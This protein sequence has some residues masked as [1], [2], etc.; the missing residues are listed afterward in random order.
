MDRV[1]LTWSIPSPANKECP[2]NHTVA[3]TPFGRFLL[4][5]K[6]WKDDPGY[7]FDETPW[8]EAEYHGWI[9]VAEAQEWA[10]KEMA[11]RCASCLG[12]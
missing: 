6:G 9:T 8:G 12:G 10:A 5:W 11:R 1:S 2:Y 4:T 3:E 7:G